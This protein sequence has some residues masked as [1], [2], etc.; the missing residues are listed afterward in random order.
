MIFKAMEIT[1]GFK[2]ESNVSDLFVKRSSGPCRKNSRSQGQRPERG[3][4]SCPGELWRRLQRGEKC[5]L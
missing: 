1:E 3:D 5:Q 2:Q 4:C